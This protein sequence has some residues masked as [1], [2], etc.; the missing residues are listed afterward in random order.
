MYCV[1]HCVF[2][3]G[4]HPEKVQFEWW[5]KEAM[6]HSPDSV[7]AN[8]HFSHFFVNEVRQAGTAHTGTSVAA[9]LNSVRVGSGQ[10]RKNKRTF[11]TFQA[12]ID[13]LIYNYKPVFTGP[14]IGDFETCYFFD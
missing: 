1:D 8:S 3:T 11:D 9:R 2:D 7:L 12:Q 10:T 14:T 6:N 13:S 5:Y 4:R